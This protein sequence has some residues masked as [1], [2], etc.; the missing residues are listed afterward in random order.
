MSL[1]WRDAALRV[2]T[3]WWRMTK[4]CSIGVR[5]IVLNDKGEMLLVRH[6]YGS[7]KWFLPGGGHHK[8][9]SPDETM[10]REMREETGLE[11]RVQSLVGVYFYTGAYKRD[12]I[13]IFECQMIGGEVQNV[14]GEIADIGWFSPDKLPPNLMIGM[15]RFL[16]DW[17]AHTAGYGRIEAAGIGAGDEI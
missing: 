3:I 11:V 4:P 8:K 10:V 1:N 7:R 17:R 2:L 13:Y 15:D 14:G 9:E 5:G 16:S 12:H 6:S